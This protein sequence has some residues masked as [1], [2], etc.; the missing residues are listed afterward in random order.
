VNV[1]QPIAISVGDPAGVG[2]RVS[3]AAAFG[4]RAHTRSVLFGDAAQLRAEARALSLDALVLV[5][6]DEASLAELPTG[7]V[8]VVDTGRV[9]ERAIAAHAPTPEGGLAQVQTLERAAKAVRGGFASALVTGPTSKSA[10]ASAGVPF[11]GQTEFLARLEGL[12]DDDVTMMFLGPKLRVALVTTHLAVADV[13]RAITSARVQRTVRH[14]AAALRRL[15][16]ERMPTLVVS[17]LN[18]HAGEQGMFGREDLDV[19]APAL[20]T[21]EGELQGRV[22]LRGPEPAESVFRAAQRGD[23]DGVVAQYHDQA[24]IASKLLDWGAAVNTTWGLSFLRTSVD[25][26]VAYDAVRTGKVDAEGMQ[27]ALALAVRLTGEPA[28]GPR[29]PRARST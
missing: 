26:G 29:D 9:P 10:I 13:P 24:T 20:R 12:A 14:L 15:V 4:A 28:P 1:G 7:A 25:H 16:H 11:I 21:L 5:E 19:I 8:A 27:A 2:P 22:L 18:P 3:V 23:I 17:G 6:R